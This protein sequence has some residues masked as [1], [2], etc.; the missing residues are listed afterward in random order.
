MWPPI[1]IFLMFG[2]ALSASITLLSTAKLF[3]RITSLLVAK[4]TGSMIAIWPFS[5]RTRP[6]QPFFFGS[7]LGAPG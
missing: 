5:I 4:N 6:G 1:S 2:D 3:L 7:V